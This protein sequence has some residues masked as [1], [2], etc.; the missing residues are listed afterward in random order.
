MYIHSIYI[1]RSVGI[2]QLFIMRYILNKCLY[3]QDII[4]EQILIKS[5]LSVIFTNTIF[6][7]VENYF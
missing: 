7:A 4:R 3:Q 5:S 2:Q 1:I 6:G